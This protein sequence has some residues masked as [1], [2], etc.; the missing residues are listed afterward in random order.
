MILRLVLAE[1]RHRP[2]RMLFLLGGY[3]FGVAVMVVLLAVGEAM[4]SQARDQSLVG[5]GDLLILPAGLSPEMLKAGG[6]SSL[7]IGIDQ[8]RFLHRQI[9]ESPRGRSEF[10]VVAASP[11]IDGRLVR[12]ARGDR[13]LQALATGEIPSRAAAVGAAPDLLA[14]TW[15]DS[16]SDRRWASPTVEQLYHEIDRFHLPYG[17]GVGDSTWAEWHYFNVLLAEDRWLYLTFMVGGRV[18]ED[19]QWGGRTLLTIRGPDGYANHT[20]DFESAT[21]R[22]DTTSANLVLGPGSAVFQRD[23]VYEVRATVDGWA[24]DF[25]VVPRPNRIFPPAEL[26]GEGLVSG[27]TVPVLAGTARGTLCRAGSGAQCLSIDG[28]PAYHDHNWGVWRDVSWEWGAA[29]GD[30]LSLL[31]GVVRS[32]DTPEQGLFAYLVD[33]LGV[34]GVF[35][36]SSIE[37]TAWRDVPG[38]VGPLRVP[39]SMRFEDRR[40]GL[41]V[42]IEATSHNVTDMERPADRY[43]VQM[44]GTARVTSPGRPPAPV[45]GFF[46]TYV[47]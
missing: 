25:T 4:L 29:S 7:F 37:T 19:G 43:F 33:D 47:D 41:L 26:G 12:V 18:G 39:S 35:R 38:P 40:R 44:R 8:A 23:G 20:R 1:L 6:T 24:L 5:G 9:L 13:E 31:Y 11:L 15:E 2:G 36:P 34:L 10:G 14:G 17:V 46:E 32:P 21:I 30:E 16:E 22:I 42:E 27:Y 45:Q 28:A 3:S